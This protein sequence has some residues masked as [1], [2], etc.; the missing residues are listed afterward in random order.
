M[1]Y[2]LKVNKTD[3]TMIEAYTED[4]LLAFVAHEDVIDDDFIFY[5]LEKYGECEVKIE[6]VF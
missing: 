3:N 5:F 6:I 1:K 2:I 4:D